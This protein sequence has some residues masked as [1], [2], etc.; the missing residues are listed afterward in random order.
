MIWNFSLQT[1][2]ITAQTNACFIIEYKNKS[3]NRFSPKLERPGKI[4]QLL[5]VRQKLT[6]MK[7]G[8]YGGSFDP[9]LPFGALFF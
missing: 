2:C 1:I 8:M 3:H 6:K 5:S 9:I 7:T 4:L